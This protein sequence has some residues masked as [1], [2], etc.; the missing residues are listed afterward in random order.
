M[1]SES[2]FMVYEFRWKFIN[3][4]FDCDG[5]SLAAYNGINRSLMWDSPSEFMDIVRCGNQRQLT[6]FRTIG[7]KRAKEII[8]AYKGVK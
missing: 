4:F 6:S 7:N 1:T 8:Q 3:D 2:I 5:L